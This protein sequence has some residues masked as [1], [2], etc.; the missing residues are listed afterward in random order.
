M[1]TALLALTLLVAGAASAQAP[2][3][4]AQ[5]QVPQSQSQPQAWHAHKHHDA[6]HQAKHLSK[7]LGLNADQQAQLTPILAD[8][9]QKMQ[10]LAANTSLDPKS[11][12]QQ[13]KAIAQDTDQKLSAIL[14][15]D[16]QQQ[17]AAMKA[18]HHHGHGRHDAPATA[19]AAA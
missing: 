9:D 2:A 10:A 6:V 1:K 19:P 18:A 12:H 15:P 4:P 3:E 11:M 13:R 17:Y 16:Q 14:T 7:E 8:R 5:N